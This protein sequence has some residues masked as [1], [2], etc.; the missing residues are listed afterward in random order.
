M[1]ITLNNTRSIMCDLVRQAVLNKIP[2]L[3]G[4]ELVEYIRD[5]A[6]GAGH[7]CY[8]AHRASPDCSHFCMDDDGLNEACTN[9]LSNASTC[10]LGSRDDFVTTTQSISQQ[11]QDLLFST[12][13]CKHIREGYD[14]F[15][16]LLNA[17]SDKRAIDACMKTGGVSTAMV[18]VFIVIG[19]VCIG[20]IAYWLRSR[21]QQRQRRRIEKE[22]DEKQQ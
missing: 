1:V 3:S 6:N 16:C 9:C 13:C 7:L 11:K 19:V 8:V 4:D 22:D 10:N 20:G 18:I 21:R 12:P 5:A 15:D 17:G 14:C 2:D